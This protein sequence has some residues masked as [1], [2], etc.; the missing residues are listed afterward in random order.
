LAI[1]LRYKLLV[2]LKHCFLGLAFPPGNGSLDPARLPSLRS[3]LVHFLLASEST[4]PPKTANESDANGDARRTALG[5]STEN[6][7]DALLLRFPR[8]RYLLGLDTEAA[9]KVLEAAFPE[10]GPLGTGRFGRGFKGD[11]DEVPGL[12]DQGQSTETP[13]E[14]RSPEME[15]RVSSNE[16]AST[17]SPERAGLRKAGSRLGR[18][19]FKGVGSWRGGD[20]PGKAAPE[21]TEGPVQTFAEETQELDGAYSRADSSGN[22]DALVQMVVDALMDICREAVRRGGSFSEE[23][24]SLQAREGAANQTDVSQMLR[25]C[26][27]FIATG[28]ARISSELLAWLIRQLCGAPSDPSTKSVTRPNGFPAKQNRQ[29]EPSSSGLIEGLDAHLDAAQNQKETLIVALL[30]GALGLPKPSEGLEGFDTE[31][32]LPVMEGLGFWEA[33][34]LLHAAHGRFSAA[35]DSLLKDRSHAAQTFAFVNKY[36]GE[37]PSGGAHAG[38]NQTPF[39]RVLRF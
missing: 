27:Q 25:F 10:T 26:A 39:S 15:E 2:Y 33:A 34:A 17:S 20:S 24:E 22:G 32:L 11:W 14:E 30:K 29:T 1:C 36:L 12:K 19:L 35:L 5:E 3:E 9:L 18:R 21:S 16:E 13:S 38:E 28:H 23:E 4:A 8:L 37:E 31:G 7:E 6:G